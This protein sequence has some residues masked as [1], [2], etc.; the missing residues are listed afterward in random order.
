MGPSSTSEAKA[1]FGR[2]IFISI[3]YT[4]SVIGVNLLDA[5][6]DL[7]Q[8]V[9]I[10]LSILPVIPAFFMLLAIL[11]FV[12]SWDEVQQRIL[13]EGALI[14]SALVGFGTFTYGWMQ[15]AIDLPPIHA[16]FILPM[17][18]LATWLSSVVIKRRYV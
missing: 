12:R 17:L 8:P 13:T 7:S 9:R 6:Q 15:G 11:A 5:A 2:M 10:G 1:Y 14:G 3:L 4:L 18:I 16:S